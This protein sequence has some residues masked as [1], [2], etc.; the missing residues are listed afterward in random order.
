MVPLSH[1][2]RC[3]GTAPSAAKMD[4]VLIANDFEANKN[5]II[6]LVLNAA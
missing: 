6:K 3:N 2:V 4:L 1:A 5:L